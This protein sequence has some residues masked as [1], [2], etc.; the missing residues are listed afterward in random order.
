MPEPGDDAP[1]FTLQNQ[2]GEPVTLSELDAEY[3]VVYFYPRADTPGCTT[4][5]C[6]FRD[7]WDTF[8]EAG[9]TV[10][11][12]SDDPVEDLADFAEKYDLP[13]DLLSDPDG[14]VAAAYDSYGE[15][16]M[17]GNTFDGVFRNTYV[18]DKGGEIVLSYEG[19]SPEEH[20]EE[21]LEDIGS[22]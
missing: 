7:E 18:V 17:F 4:E 13:F 1:D 22:L 2:D 9:V 8:A 11:G 5:A 12:I 6:G 14:E 15:K 19:V 10:V 16:N 21:I 3:T 20:A